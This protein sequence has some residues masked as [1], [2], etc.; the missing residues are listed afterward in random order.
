M[1]ITTV[2]TAKAQGGGQVVDLGVRPSRR[3]CAARRR[4][5]PA[6]ESSACRRSIRAR[7]S[8]GHGHRVGAALLGDGDR[9]HRDAWP[10]PGWTASPSRRIDPAVALGL[11][12]AVLDARHVAQVDRRAID[13]VDDHVPRAQQ[14]SRSTSP[15]SR[16][17]ARL[18]TVQLPAPCST[19]DTAGRRRCPPRWCAAPPGL[20][21]RGERAGCAAVRRRP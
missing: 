10:S 11:R 9:H 18:P 19:L 17:M 14:R 15:A 21:D 12:G 20:R 1:K 3:S 13:D 16:T 5:L 8:L 6:A 4:A 2:T 7:V